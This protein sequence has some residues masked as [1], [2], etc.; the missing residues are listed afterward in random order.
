MRG[1][2]GA[3][4]KAISLV[5]ATVVLVLISVVASAILWFWVSNFT[6]ASTAQQPALNER[7]KI[8]A[9]EVS[10]N[11][12][13][14][15]VRNVGS[16]ATT[17]HYVYVLKPDGTL[18]KAQSVSVPLS[19]GRSAPAQVTGVSGASGHPYTV[20]VVTEHGVEALY[21]FVWPVAI[22]KA[23]AMPTTRNATT[24]KSYPQSLTSTELGYD[25]VRISRGAVQ[26]KLW[27]DFE[28][29][30]SGWSRDGGS[31]GIVDGGF[32]GEALRGSDDGKGLGG[33]SHFYNNTDL[34]GYTS[35]W[36]S[37]KAKRD[38]GGRGYYGI[39]MRD[40]DSKRLYTI[41]IYRMTDKKVM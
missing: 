19:P 11:D 10:G 13:K 38:T 12:V 3:N 7:I 40:S 22:A 31:W 6:S 4:R 24:T 21:T 25:L 1:L 20:K 34:S 9:V 18:L 37:V 16:V 15:Y 5:V 8:E 27:T 30:P 2:K 29:M 36:A 35:L 28:S 23:V 39:S 14:V 32:K 33:A 26:G 41:E 17:I